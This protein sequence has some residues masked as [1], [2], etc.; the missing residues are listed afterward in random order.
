M[1]KVIATL[2]LLLGA[3]VPGAVSAALFQPDSATASSTFSSLYDISNTIDGSGL[4][5]NFAPN[6]LH[7]DYVA[8]NHWT[9]AA[10][11]VPGA[12]ANYFFDSA[13]TI[14]TF[15]LWNHR[16]NVIAANAAYGVTLFDLILRDD[17]GNQLFGLLDQSAQ[18][19]VASA[20][21]YGFAAVA[22][23]YQVDF[24]IKS[25]L[26]FDLGGASP[27]YT[28]LAEVAF[29][30]ASPV[31]LPA[32]MWLLGSAMVALGAGAQRFRSQRRRVSS[33]R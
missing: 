2:I 7:A 5:A 20:Q 4:P 18:T 31:P 22:G 16:S 32:G 28:G 25:N 23:V 30:A 29:S 27:N 9:T 33:S 1:A 13:V 19:G 11:Q 8:H 10:N 3:A 26:R 24:I 17:D 21:S 12:T 15:H 14:G 6:D